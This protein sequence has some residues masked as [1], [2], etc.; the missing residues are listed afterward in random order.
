MSQILVLAEHRDDQLLPE[1][2]VALRLASELGE[3][4]AVLVS[5]PQTPIASLVDQLGA[6]GA[7]RVYHYPGNPELLVG[8]LVDG[9]AAAVTAADQLGAVLLPETLD[10]REAG[11][12]LAVRLATGFIN[13]ASDIALTAGGYS[14]TQQVLGG[15]FTVTAV[16]QPGVLP[17]I[18]VT[19][20]ARE[21]APTSPGQQPAVVE[22][23][24][25]E[26]GSPGAQIV[27]RAQRAATSNRPDLRSATVV[28]SG[29]R[30]LGSAAGF[31]L[32]EQLAD[33]LGG[34]VG[35]TRAAVDAGYCDHQLQVGQTGVTV[36]PELYIAA[37]V[38]G[39]IQHQ[40]GMQ[41][42]KHIIAIDTDP[43][44]PI[45][46]IADLGVVGDAHEILPQLIDQLANS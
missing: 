1:T 33:A 19:A 5:P 10:A 21:S 3:P 27:A 11:A 32:V 22:L 16:A 17:I 18:G 44:A 25:A 14:T 24:V 2:A 40:A 29:G 15:D 26:Q 39:A 37:G 45:L 42:A 38:S 23:P 34:A 6:L 41:S 28:V 20:T 4:A 35:A 31:Q 7:T 13:D 46:E 43:D 12:R 30:G 9:L 36:S 8:T